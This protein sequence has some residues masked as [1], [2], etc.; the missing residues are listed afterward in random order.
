[1]PPEVKTT[2]LGLA[3]I[4]RAMASRDSSTTRRAARPEA[5]RDDGLPG[6]VSCAVIAATASAYIGVVAAWSR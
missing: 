5:C 1:M 4:A 6:R 3:P 2:S